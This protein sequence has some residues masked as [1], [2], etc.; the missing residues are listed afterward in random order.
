MIIKKLKWSISF[1]VPALSNKKNIRQPRE[2]ANIRMEE[3]HHW[4][5]RRKWWPSSSS[6]S[7]WEQ[8]PGPE[9]GQGPGQRW[10]CW[11]GRPSPRRWK[12][13]WRRTSRSG[14]PGEIWGRWTPCRGR[15]K[16]LTAAGS[17][18]QRFRV[19]FMRLFGLFLS[20]FHQSKLNILVLLSGI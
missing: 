9:P 10:H 20:F 5:V 2:E 15:L 16:P 8:G 3:A 11:R 6:P 12:F 19:G 14:H 4:L 13:L 7:S 17:W 1:R 18:N